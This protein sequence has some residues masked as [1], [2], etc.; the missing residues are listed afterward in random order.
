MYGDKLPLRSLRLSIKMAA[1]KKEKKT[2]PETIA[3]ENLKQCRETIA[4]IIPK[5]AAIKCLD[6]RV[7]HPSNRDE[8]KIIRHFNRVSQSV[9]LGP[10]N[11]L[12]WNLKS[13]FQ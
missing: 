12:K 5:S 9:F 3:R 13:P 7:S 10:Y 2:D 6:V 4:E 8:W 11:T 1:G